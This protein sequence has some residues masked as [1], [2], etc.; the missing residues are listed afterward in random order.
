VKI[1]PHH[2]AAEIAD[3]IREDSRRAATV[4]APRPIHTNESNTF[5]VFAIN[6]QKFRVGVA[7]ILEGE[8]D[9]E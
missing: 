9:A 2:I 8:P 6:G 7:V 3:L 5:E 4:F 1:E